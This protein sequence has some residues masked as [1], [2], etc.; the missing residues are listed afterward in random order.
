V[1]GVY[2]SPLPEE[3]ISDVNEE[4]QELFQLTLFPNP[5]NEF[6]SLQLPKGHRN[7][8]SLVI[9]DAMGRV[10]FDKT[11]NN[12]DGNMIVVPTQNWTSGIYLYTFG[13]GVSKASGK[14]IV[15]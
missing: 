1:G 14:F 9:T 8:G 6:V 5:A 7:Q 11:I 3:L 13:T 10:K 4:S 15:E 2:K 12:N